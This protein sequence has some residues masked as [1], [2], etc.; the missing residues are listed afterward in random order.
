MTKQAMDLKARVYYG[1]VWEEEREGEIY[2]IIS[3]SKKTK[4]YYKKK[5]NK[6]AN[7]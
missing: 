1:T 2:A 4:K 5:E 3:V 7:V 6:L